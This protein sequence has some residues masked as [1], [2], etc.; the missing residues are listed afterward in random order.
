[1]LG[2]GSREIPEVERGVSGR[3]L[4]AEALALRKRPGHLALHIKHANS[5]AHPR[6][7]D[8]LSPRCRGPGGELQ[9]SRLQGYMRQETIPSEP[10]V[11]GARGLFGALLIGVLLSLALPVEGRAG[12][13][14]VTSCSSQARSDDTSAYR[15]SQ[16]SRRMVIK[17]ACN[18]FTPGRTGLITAN[19]KR[20]GRVRRGEHATLVLSAPP[21]T[22]LTSI[23]WS[24]QASR[25]DCGFG[26]EM[27]GVGPHQPARYLARLP[28]T[29]RCR[30]TNASSAGRPRPRTF[31]L[32]RS[33]QV[34]Q[35]V[36]C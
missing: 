3:G 1:M 31:S 2:R 23:R 4:E 19:Q 5:E 12:S 16:S 14:P 24:G 11:S 6:V 9:A 25:G 8:R 20:R 30:L 15:G 10:F 33:T 17:R 34:V 36:T 21:G 27:Y 32:G 18:I 22:A 7:L 29:R 26:V 13:F 28:A 35:R